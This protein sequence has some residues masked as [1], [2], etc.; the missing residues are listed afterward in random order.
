MLGQIE[1]FEA[2]NEFSN[3]NSDFYLKDIYLI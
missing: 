2:V 1:I 3:K